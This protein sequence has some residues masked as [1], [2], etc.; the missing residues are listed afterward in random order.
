MIHS[1]FEVNLEYKMNKKKRSKINNKEKK[2]RGKKYL[3][4][5]HLNGI[6]NGI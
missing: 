6:A 2:G 3:K 5:T 4:Q 1:S